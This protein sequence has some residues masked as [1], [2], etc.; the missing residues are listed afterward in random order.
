MD[1]QV[2]PNKKERLAPL[3]LH[4]YLALRVIA[5]PVSVTMTVAITISVTMTVAMTV[6]IFI[7]CSEI[8]NTITGMP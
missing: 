2:L 7:L 5:V 4:F 6:A 3:L 1:Y 8:L